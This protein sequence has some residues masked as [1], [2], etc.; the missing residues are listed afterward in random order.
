MKGRHTDGTIVRGTLGKLDQAHAN[1]YPS[2]TLVHV[3]HHYRHLHDAPTEGS[4]APLLYP[5]HLSP[6][7]TLS[8]YPVQA[9]STTHGIGAATL[10]SVIICSSVGVKLSSSHSLTPAPMSA[11]PDTVTTSV[12]LRSDPFSAFSSALTLVVGIA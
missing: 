2:A 9:S 12:P 11:A 8:F 5:A 10:R 6:P 1:A 4:I 3:R 7:S